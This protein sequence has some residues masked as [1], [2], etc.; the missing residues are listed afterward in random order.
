MAAVAAGSGLAGCGLIGAGA[1]ANVLDSAQTLTI[2][3]SLPLQGPDQARQQ[4]I[5]N[6]EKLAL[7]E[8]GGRVGAFHVSFASLTDS[9][10]GAGSWTADD[11][12]QAARTASSDRSTI[13]YIGDFDS[14]A[15]AISVP[16]LNEGGILQVSPASTYIG[17]TQAAAGD[18]RG[19]PDRYYPSPGPR[20]FA[21]LA[22]S[23]VV[24]GRAMAAYM[25]ELG[26]RRLFVIGDPDVFNA[27]IATVVAGV[28][29]R[30]GVSVVGRAVVDTPASR[31]SPADYRASAAAVAAA[32]PDAVLFAGTAGAGSQALWRALHVAAPRA[33]LFAAS[34]LATPAFVAAAAAGG[35]G[36]VTYV[37]SPVLD[38]SRYPPE[39]Q[40]VLRSY[41]TVF[42]APGTAFTL[43]GYEAM[44]STLAAIRAAGSHG[45]DRASVVRAFFALGRHPSVLG[46][47]AVTPTGDTTLANMAGYRVGPDGRPRLERMLGGSG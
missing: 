41:R 37:T 31:S 22:P 14:P 33:K 38:A 17:L 39:A 2:Y 26:V 40:R 30:S 9:N 46:T 10:V 5:V 32:R 45:G 20:T 23:D 24:E 47:Y 12:L 4:S 43:Y 6:G 15:S 7:A 28:A 18:G 35:A 29:P 16:L 25:R 42:G 8:T 27:N 36:G 3:S 21:R 34:S 11:T 44:K 1:G 13:A 19:E